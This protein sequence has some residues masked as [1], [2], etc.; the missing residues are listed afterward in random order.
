MLFSMGNPRLYIFLLRILLTF[1]FSIKSYGGV[2]GVLR[3]YP[4]TAFAHLYMSVQPRLFDFL[5]LIYVVGAAETPVS[6][7]MRLRPANWINS[8]ASDSRPVTF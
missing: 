6:S 5:I 1:F 2:E 3:S 7:P 8:T 4:I